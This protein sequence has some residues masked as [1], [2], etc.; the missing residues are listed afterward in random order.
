MDGK[1]NL[2]GRARRIA[3]ARTVI[4]IV[5]GIALVVFAIATI[6]GKKEEV[7]VQ[8]EYAILTEYFTDRHYTC[9]VL[10][11]SGSK[12]VL[13]SDSLKKTF[14]RY[15]DGFQFIINSDSYTLSI[16]HRLSE[17]ESITFKTNSKAFVGYR[18]QTFK[19]EVDKNVLSKVDKCSSGDTVLD[20]SSYIG[21]IEEAQFELTNA[22]LNSGYSADGVIANYEWK[23]K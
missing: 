12:C 4:L 16:V 10:T 6:F 8:K 19:C 9:E 20:I 5:L 11:E 2:Y 14:Y 13:Y 18:N 22:L 21:I 15:D 1:F 23:Q 17:P 3:L 7:V